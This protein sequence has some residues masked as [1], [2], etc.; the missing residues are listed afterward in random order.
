VPA[1]DSPSNDTTARKPELRM[2]RVFD[3][4]KRLVFE[5]WSKAEYVS[6]WFTPA[7]LTTPRCEVDLRTG[8]VFRLVMRMPNGVEFPMD[9]KFTEVVPNERIVFTATIHG[10]VD[11]HT[12]V[13]F[14]ERDGKT[15]LSVHQVYSHETDATRGAHAGWTQ[16]L[17]QLAEHLRVASAIV[18][19][20]ER[21]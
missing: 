10:G 7:P 13:T 2:T 8:G 20:E 19:A 1:K 9:A 18:E 17:N 16:T 15:T 4:P 12:T 11:V 21:G 5:A 6:R 14:V 3:A